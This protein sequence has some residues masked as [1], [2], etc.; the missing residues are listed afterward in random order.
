M[1][2]KLIT[3]FT[4]IITAATINFIP[5]LVRL[6]FEGDYYSRAATIKLASAAIAKI[7]S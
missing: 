2:A 1:I 5:A 3:V 4:R 6:L 7:T